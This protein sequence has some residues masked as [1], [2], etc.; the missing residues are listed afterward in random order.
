[1]YTN[2]EGNGGGTVSVGCGFGGGAGCVVVGVSGGLGT[3]VIVAV[4]VR[5]PAG[6]PLLPIVITR[7][8]SVLVEILNPSTVTAML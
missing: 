4:V 6:L 5:V 7:G 1:M 8:V 3:L 2:R